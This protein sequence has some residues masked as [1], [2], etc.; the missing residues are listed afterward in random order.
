MSKL[1]KILK[2]RAT[3]WATQRANDEIGRG[4]LRDE[5][6]LSSGI[7]ES[8]SLSSSAPGRKRAV[9]ALDP[10]LLGEVT[11]VVYAWHNV[12][13]GS[14]SWVFPNA[15]Q[16]I[17]AAKAMRNAVAWAIVR[18]KQTEVSLEEARA[19]GDVLLEHTA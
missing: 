14:M 12:Q 8:P 5:D 7:H 15:R 6:E 17:A 13:P 4:D 9:R 1:A 18:G 10:L 19:V 16:A 11:L 2:A 3:A